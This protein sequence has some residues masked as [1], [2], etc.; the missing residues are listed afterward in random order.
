MKIAPREITSKKSPPV[1]GL[2]LW[3]GMEA[4]FWGAIFQGAIFLVR[5]ESSSVSNNIKLQ[6]F[7]KYFQNVQLFSLNRLNALIFM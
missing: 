6:I 3:L 7:Q 1:L 2:G 4:I 5:D